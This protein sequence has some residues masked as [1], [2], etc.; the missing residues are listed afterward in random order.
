M[1]S[2]PRRQLLFFFAGIVQEMSLNSLSGLGLGHK[3]GEYK[4]YFQPAKRLRKPSMHFAGYQYE[5]GQGK[6]PPW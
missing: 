2:T 5:V 3:L 1:S 6:L 4:L